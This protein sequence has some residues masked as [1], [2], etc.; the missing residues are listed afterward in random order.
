MSLQVRSSDGF[1]KAG[2]TGRYMSVGHCGGLPMAL[3]QLKGPLEIFVKNR[4]CRPSS[5]FDLT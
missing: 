5:G 4:E 2:W 3:L 1:P